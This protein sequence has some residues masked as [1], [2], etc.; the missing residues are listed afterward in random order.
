MA[1]IAEI[2]RR[3][4][5]DALSGKMGCCDVSEWL[6]ENG[7]PVKVYWRPLTGKQQRQIDE[8]GTEVGRVCLSVK[9]RALDAAGEAIFADTALAGM[10]QDYDYD[11]LR[12]IAYIIA[13]NIGQDSNEKGAEI[14]KE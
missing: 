4:L 6:D 2:G 1:A 14:E 12:A 3:H 10:M 13:G 9:L 5:S 11:V 8:A 7:L